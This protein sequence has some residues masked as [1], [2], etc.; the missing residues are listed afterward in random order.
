MSFSIAINRFLQKLSVSQIVAVALAL[1]GLIGALDYLSGFELGMSLFYLGPVALASWY[2]GKTP[3]I[4]MAALCSVVWFAADFAAGHQYSHPIISLW[5][6]LIRL[7]FFYITARL[8]LSLREAL[9]IQQQ[10][11]QTDALTGLH[12]R[13][14]FDQRLSYALALATRRACSLAVAYLDL[15]NFKTVND[16]WGH[17]IGDAVLQTT[18][19]VLQAA[20]RAGDTA[21]RL[22]G[23]EFALILPD[24]DAHTADTLIT[25]LRERLRLAFAA[26]DWPVG[27]SVGVVIAPPGAESAQVLEQADR[28]MYEVKRRGKGSHAVQTLSEWDTVKAPTAT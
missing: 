19:T 2:A 21:A 14:A 15:D 11:A 6:T 25:R 13:R 22:G 7:G 26:H 16:R 18:G 24:T 23:D 17:A 27:T 12:S 5:N 1:L 28:L 8:L 4:A 9:Q 3:G 20:L 10:L